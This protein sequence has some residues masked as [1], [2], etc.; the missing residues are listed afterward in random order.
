[1][2]VIC[3]VF[4]FELV[5][6]NS[7]SMIPNL[8]SGDLFL[9]RP[10]ALLGAGDVAVCEDPEDPDSLVVLRVVGLPGEEISFWKNHIRIDG[11]VVQHSIEDPLLYV[12]NTAEEEFEYVV[13]IAVENFGGQVYT[14]ALMDK[15][16]G[17]GGGKTVVPNDHFYLVADNRNM[18]RDSRNFGPVPIDSCVGKAVLVLWPGEESGDLTRFSRF[19][20]FL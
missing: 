16:S 12:D 5:Q 4:F 7:Y 13:R 15:G 8:V 11:D 3:R 9:M 20:E 14:V 2:A 19:A 18:G 10:G 1:M 6:T 17:K